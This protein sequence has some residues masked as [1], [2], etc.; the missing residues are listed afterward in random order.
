MPRLVALLAESYN[1]HVR[2]GA[3]LAVGIS[4]AGT[5][6]S[7]AE[8]MEIVKA[9]LEDKVSFVRQGALM[10]M[11]LMLMQENE[12]RCPAVKA[13]REKINS[14]VE[15]KHQGVVAKFGAT[16]AAGILDAGGRNMCVALTSRTGF[17]RQGAVV[18]MMCWLHYWYWY[19]LL[20]F[21]SL[22]L[23]PTAIIGVTKDMKI[24]NKFKLNCSTKVSHC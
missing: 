1:P 22:T 7:N 13:L 3:C 23:A 10:S 17:L 16:L 6:A 21:F 9:M 2:Y 8:A 24:A 15:D 19:P 20:Q 5:G 14:V 4:C 12:A 18:G 11:A